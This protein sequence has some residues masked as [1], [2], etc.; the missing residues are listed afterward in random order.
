MFFKRKRK[1]LLKQL[2][3]IDSI[4]NPNQY[5]KKYKELY[6]LYKANKLHKYSEEEILNKL[7]NKLKENGL[8]TF[9]EL[10]NKEQ[11]TDMRIEALETDFKEIDNDLSTLEDKLKDFDKLKENLD[12][13]NKKLRFLDSFIISGAKKRSKATVQKYNKPTN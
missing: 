11:Q 3:K 9:T 12:I 5:K 10:I 4:D 8:K 6:Q 2:K 7:D 1:T 13:I